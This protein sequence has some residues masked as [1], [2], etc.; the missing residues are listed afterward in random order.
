MAEGGTSIG[1][2]RCSLNKWQYHD[3]YITV[4]LVLQKKLRLKVEKVQIVFALV[5]ASSVVSTL[6]TTLLSELVIAADQAYL[7]VTN[8]LIY[9]AVYECLNIHEPASNV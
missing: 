1:C 4:I 9:C 6:A 2:F 8:L 7:T 3:K 5:Y